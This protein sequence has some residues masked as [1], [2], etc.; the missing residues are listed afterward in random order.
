[1]LDLQILPNMESVMTITKIE[2]D[3]FTKLIKLA[4]I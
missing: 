4:G 1:M 2:W 3:S